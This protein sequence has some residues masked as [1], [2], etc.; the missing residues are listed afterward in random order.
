MV[1]WIGDAELLYQLFRLDSDEL[2]AY[3]SEYAVARIRLL[4]LE[5]VASRNNWVWPIG[6]YI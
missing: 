6:E 1:L 5:T 4:L 3:H 2:H